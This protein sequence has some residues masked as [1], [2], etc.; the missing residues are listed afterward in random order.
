MT[1]QKNMGVQPDSKRHAA[2][3]AERA[4]EAGRDYAS[5]TDARHKEEFGQF[6]TPLGIARFMA[7]QSSF[8]AEH[9]S[10][11]DPGAGAGILGAALIDAMMLQQPRP[12]S[13]MLHAY[14]HDARLAPRLHELFSS[15]RDCL[16]ADV[17]FDFRV[18]ETDFLHENA[19][20]VGNESDL[21]TSGN[22][23]DIV[24]SNPPYYKLAGT[25]ERAVAAA[26]VVNGQPNVYS[27]FMATAAALLRQEGE[28]IFITPR[29]FAAGPY[30]GAFRKWFFQRMQPQRLHLFESR[31]DAFRHDDVLQESVI[32]K[33]VRRDGWMCS[34]HD[35][36]VRVSASSGVADIGTAGVRS[37]PIDRIIDPADSHRVLHIPAHEEQDRIIQ[38]FRNWPSSLSAMNL[39]ISTGPVVG[40]RARDHLREAEPPNDAW[41]PLLWMQNLTAMRVSW[42]LDS[43]K[44]QYIIKNSASG[45]L[46]LSNTKTYVL[47][48]R[49]SAKEQTRRLTAAVLE[50]GMVP[51]DW[52]GLEN[53]VNYIHRPGGTLTRKKRTGWQHSSTARF[54]T[55]ISECLMAT[56]K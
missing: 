1:T 11:L 23:Y 49:F 47:L 44:A 8:R 28:L 53:H 12:R 38:L 43:K 31:R 54:S 24:I 52:V 21:F 55:R 51:C 26:P 46:L 33:A 41:A 29:S 18:D 10:I 5:Q 35:V 37:V 34:R 2:S 15:I 6:L 39:N 50:P 7:S 14:E 27:L 42:P 32:L 13:I 22:P 25:D 4:D 30:F 45:K 20:R 9:I 3:F 17:A 16:G 48:R 40:F 19:W 56:H 36:C